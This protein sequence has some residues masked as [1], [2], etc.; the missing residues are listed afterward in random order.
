MTAQQAYDQAVQHHR[1]GR[2]GEADALYRQVL[3]K[4][5][6][7]TLALYYRGTIAHQ[8]GQY[9]AAVELL[10]RTIEIQPTMLEA[11]NYLGSAQHLA[12]Q[13]DAAAQTF[14]AL[15]KRKPDSADAL[16][17]LG[18]V[19]R[20]L[21]RLDESID[22][23]RQALQHLPKSPVIHNNLGNALQQRGDLD[24]AVA[25]FRTAVQLAPN[26]P[27]AWSNL[28][29]AT[30]DQGLLDEAIAS[31]RK[32]IELQPGDHAIHSNLL[33]TL[34]F[35][36]A[37][38]LA[39]IAGENEVWYQRHAEPL[40]KRI[41]PHHNDR[42]P[43]RRLR[44]GYVSPHFCNHC[45]A[46]F[47][48][49]LLGHHDHGSFEITCY[50]D[51]TRPDG[52][53][54]RLRGFADVWRATAGLAD[55]DLAA[56]IR[57]D[58]IDILVDLSLHMQSNRLLVFAQKPAPVQVTWLGYPA[59]TGL[60]TIDYRLTDA[61]LD[62]PGTND[63]LYTERSI[64]LPDAFWCYDPLTDEPAPNELPAGTTFGCLNNFCK[65]NDGVL[66]LWSKVLAA[67]P[68]SSMLILSEPG[69]H[70]QRVLDR[71]GIDPG[72]IEFIAKRPR[73]QYLELYHRISIALDTF[74]SNGHTTSLDGLWM[75]VPTVTLAGTEP[76]GRAGVCQLS[77]L[78]MTEFIA[79]SPDEFVKI[80]T[81]LAGDR[82]R[83]AAIRSTLRQKL[84]QSP[85]M[86]GQKFARSVEAAFRR[87]WRQWCSA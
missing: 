37:H 74:P 63:Q 3:Q 61:Y 77:I 43:D 12:G 17:N 33:F 69:S 2:L 60:H 85:L 26:Y 48:V 41:Q 18:T 35:H 45:Q 65:V 58:R 67:V 79:Q 51:V 86:D 10:A 9:Q 29:S 71:L 70:R 66:D 87:M 76:R 21:G 7:H 5:P 22:A 15:L 44:I 62:P 6:N 54:E 46:L 81:T 38:D 75:G 19:L 50:T 80:A 30:K 1:A 27:Q 84:E 11:Y 59:S 72:R 34:H 14:Q 57:D 25:S 4:R 64:R 36:P 83:L 68:D 82:S 23:Y 78:G 31:Y 28:A 16:N 47:L 24:A 32:A 42:N 56:R 8:S 20:A 53:T 40:K 55:N 73:Q 13:L 52:V 39:R 49:P